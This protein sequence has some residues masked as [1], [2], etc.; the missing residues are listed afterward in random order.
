MIVD[1]DL[2]SAINDGLVKMIT[3]D[4]RKEL[5]TLQLDFKALRDEGSNKVIGL[6]DGQKI[7]IQAGLTKLNIL[8]KI[9]Q[10]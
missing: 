7:M 1:F 4:K 2:N 5:S 9:F 6:S 8:E 10:N 3:I